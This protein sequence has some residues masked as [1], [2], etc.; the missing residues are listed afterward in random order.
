MPEILV[1]GKIIRT[2]DA[3]TITPMAPWVAKGMPK[4]TENFSS[5]IDR[6]NTRLSLIAVASFVLVTA[7]EII[8]RSL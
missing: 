4:V 3:G 5:R 2:P 6:F 7:A 8:R 1:R